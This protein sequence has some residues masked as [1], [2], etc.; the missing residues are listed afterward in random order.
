MEIDEPPL[1]QQLIEKPL[2]DA[3]LRRQPP[4][5]RDLVMR[6]VVDV[7][8]W[9]ALEAEAQKLH[10]LGKRLGLGLAVMGPERLE[11]SV[12]PEAVEVFETAVDMRIAL[13]VVEQ[14]AAVR[15][16]QK[17][18]PLAR[19]RR[20]QPV[21]RLS[22]LSCMLELRLRRQR[23]QRLRLHALHPLP[24]HGERLHRPDALG[25]Q[26]LDLRA[27]YVRDKVKAVLGLPD[28]RAVVGPAAEGARGARNRARRLGLRHERLEARPRHAG[29]VRAA[30]ETDCLDHAIAE[31]QMRPL[32]L[33][34]L[35]LGE[36]VRVDGDLHHMIR[37]RPAAQLRVDD[38]VAEAAQLRAA[39]D[40]LE[41]VCPAFPTAQCRARSSRPAAAPAARREKRS[42]KDDVGAPLESLPGRRHGRDK[43]ATA[44]DLDNAPSG[45]PE[46][47]QMRRLV[48]VA[49]LSK[50]TRFG[51]GRTRLG[52]FAAQAG[53]IQGDGM[54]A[55]RES[56]EIRCRKTY[57][58][59][60]ALHMPLPKFPPAHHGWLRGPPRL[61]P[62]CGKCAGQPQRRARSNRPSLPRRARRRSNATRA[63]RDCQGRPPP[64][65][66]S[67]PSRPGVS[68]SEAALGEIPPVRTFTTPAY[69]PPAAPQARANRPNRSTA[70]A[71]QTHFP[72]SCMPKGSRCPTLR[73]GAVL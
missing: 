58:A 60:D 43:T 12:E 29:V 41:K 63:E 2:P 4:Q 56:H 25:L 42:L 44:V 40:A 37:L 54:A 22:G 20:K 14:I 64:H 18:E 38:L 26:L 36:H 31:P 61:S 70:N 50:Q 13:H 52:S 73:R 66:G 51:V 23:P 72:Y 39:F 11:L 15:F 21:L 65:T 8:L 59:V 19:L 55:S 1:P 57:L 48:G 53:Q 68:R 3:V 10:Q 5:R 71:T 16:R 24:A 67:D 62:A 32:G 34:A 69:P 33:H 45:F 6:V 9:M 35:H 27:P 30:L 46:L 47:R 28:I 49:L 17:V 7:R